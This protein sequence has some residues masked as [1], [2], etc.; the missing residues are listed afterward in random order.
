MVDNKYL[1]GFSLIEILIYLALTAIVLP[2]VTDLLVRAGQITSQSQREALLL[3]EIEFVTTDLNK[4]IRFSSNIDS[5]NPGESDNNLVLDNGAVSYFL[6][7][8]GQL[9]KSADGQDFILSAAEVVLNDLR[10]YHVGGENNANVIVEFVLEPKK[11]YF[12][13][14]KLSIP[15]QM[16]V[17]LR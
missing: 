14:K 17:S 5:P 9:I 16:E 8:Q 3:Q 1:K 12:K 7:P 4:T 11:E 2:L 10:F 13:L 15:I 6:S